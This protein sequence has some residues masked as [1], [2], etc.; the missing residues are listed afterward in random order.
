M[1]I[2]KFI[3]TL[4]I[5]IVLI[6][7]FLFIT[8]I[9]GEPVQLI[10]G[11]LLPVLCSFM[12]IIGLFSA[13]TSFKTWDQAKVSWM[14]LL[15]G[16]F[17]WFIAEAIYFFFEVIKKY[18]MEELYPSAADV[19]WLF[20]YIPLF[21]GMILLIIGYK[22]SGLTFG[23]WKS[24]LLLIGFLFLIITGGLIIKLL[25]P[26]IKDTE[27]PPLGKFVYLFYPIGDLCLLLP[28][29][30]LA[31]ITSLFG[32][33]VFSRPW[34][35]ITLGFL[36]FAISDILYS[37]LSWL[38]LYKAGSVTDFGWNI[39]YLLVAIAGFYQNKLVRS[40]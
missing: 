13:F 12:A 22:K 31:Y 3:W 21:T 8:R 29:G 36:L 11:D 16:I 39:G 15:T 30:L 14:L 28:V 1:K 20:G 4:T 2:S 35:Y 37:Y 24:R 38:S 25:I 9:G 19:F 40:A 7:I 33:G 5:S 10:T 32:K 6:N 34:Q 26:I 17:S 27:T 18:N 23:P